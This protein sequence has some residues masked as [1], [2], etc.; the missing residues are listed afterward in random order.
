MK[1]PKTLSPKAAALAERIAN[2]IIRRQTKLA[3]KLNR[4]TQHWNRASK[5]I[6]LF[7]ARNNGLSQY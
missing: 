4:R 6:A 1:Q 7:F 5:L 2:G 3:D